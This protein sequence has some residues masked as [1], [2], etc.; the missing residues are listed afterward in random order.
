MNNLTKIRVNRSAEDVFEAFVDPVKIGNFWFSSSSERWSA[1]RAITLRYDEYNAE[2][3]IRVLEIETNRK[4]VFRWGADGGGEGHV[5]TITLTESKSGN[6][7]NA[8]D[9]STVVTVDETG[10][11]E[12]DEQLL[13]L[14]LD[15]KEGW[16]YAL[17]CLKAYL[18]FGVT[19]LRA[20]LVKG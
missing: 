10:F 11:D 7:D 18:E 20:G 12:R 19:H 16:V 4:I 17:T 5:V 8:G 14:M 15:N 2:G 3:A 9:V 13:P 6:A 1:G